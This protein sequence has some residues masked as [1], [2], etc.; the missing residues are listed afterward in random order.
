M[1]LDSG[2][3]SSALHQSP[4]HQVV[5]TAPLIWIGTLCLQPPSGLGVSVIAVRGREAARLVM[6][7]Q[8][9]KRVKKHQRQR[10]VLPVSRSFHLPAPRS[11]SGP[12]PPSLPLYPAHG[13]PRPHPA[14]FPF[15]LRCTTMM[16]L[17]PPLAL[18]TAASLA[19]FLCPD[20][21]VSLAIPLPPHL[22]AHPHLPFSLTFEGFDN[23]EFVGEVGP[24]RCPNMDVPQR[25]DAFRRRHHA[26]VIQGVRHSPVSSPPPV[27]LLLKEPSLA[28]VVL[29]AQR[30][31][32]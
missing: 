21:S 29:S 17:P 2:L 10:S 1:V 26:L 4:A 32:A 5:S 16:V 25:H 3:H 23:L 8:R 24:P 30:Q 20:P 27:P 13:L 18:R 6:V 7:H 15:P 19:R 9:P 31:T 28:E 11:V 22:A 14:F 12:P